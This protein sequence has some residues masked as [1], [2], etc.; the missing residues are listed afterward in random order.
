MNE[1]KLFKSNSV[2]LY[3]AMDFELW[4]RIRDG[5]A[6]TPNC[7]QRMAC[8]HDSE[9]GHFLLSIPECWLNSI[10]FQCQR[11]PF[12]HRGKVWLKRWNLQRLWLKT[13]TNWHRRSLMSTEQAWSYWLH[14]HSSW[15]PRCKG[16]EFHLKL[17]LGP[18]RSSLGVNM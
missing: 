6:M 3:L 15:K 2:R 5:K 11:P 4:N 7:K 17:E 12:P 16:N 13:G 9:R 10:C 1:E 18:P 8:W 14:W